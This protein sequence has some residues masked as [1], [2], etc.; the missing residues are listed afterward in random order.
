MSP[1]I[2]STD[3]LGLIAREGCFIVIEPGQTT[4]PTRPDRAYLRTPDGKAIGINLG[5]FQ[6]NLIEVPMDTL[7]DFIEASVVRERS[8]G[9][10]ELTA[11]GMTRGLKVRTAD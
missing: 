5:N 7:G 10:Y 8:A 11:D 1:E 3:L 9:V 2:G 6:S 4:T